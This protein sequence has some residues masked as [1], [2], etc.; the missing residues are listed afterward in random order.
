MRTGPKQS[1][2]TPAC[3]LE[4][5]RLHMM[6]KG[7]KH[8]F[9]FILWGKSV[10]EKHISREWNHSVSSLSQFLSA[11]LLLSLHPCQLVFLSLYLCFF[12][13]FS[14]PLSLLLL[15][16]PF[17]TLSLASRLPFSLSFFSFS[18]TSSCTTFCEEKAP[19]FSWRID[20]QHPLHTL[21]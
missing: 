21:Q 11:F 8:S 4:G 20:W 15:N 1:Q 17:A 13:Q 12:G 18:S 6:C 5:H 2:S 16:F 10:T 14:F 3:Q 9:S 19:L 7:E